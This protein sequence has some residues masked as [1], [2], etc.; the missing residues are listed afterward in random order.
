MKTV[1]TFAVALCAILPT[2][3]LAADVTPT[4]A[5]GGLRLPAIFSDNMVLQAGVPVPVWGW[6]APG[7]SVTISVAGQSVTAKADAQGK[8]KAM[9]APLQVADNLT[10]TAKGA[11]ATWTAAN[12]LVGEVWLAS[13]QSNMAMPKSHDDRLAGVTT[14][15]PENRQLRLFMIRQ[16][17]ESDV[18]LEDLFISDKERR[19]RWMIADAKTVP[20]FSAAGYY[21]GRDLQAALNRPVGV[22]QTAIGGVPAQ[23]YVNRAVLSADPELKVFVERS[24]KQWQETQ[25]R[26][27]DFVKNEPALLKHY[28]A[29]AAKAVA[30]GKKPPT[31]PMRPKVE[32]NPAW[33]GLAYNSRIAPIIPYAIKGVVWYQGESNSAG[34][35]RPLFPALIQSWRK[36]WGQRDFPFLFVQITYQD[37][38]FR[39]VQ[40]QITKTVP[41]TGM[42]V[43]SDMGMRG[44]PAH[45][46]D[47]APVGA[48]LALAARALAY[49]EKTEGSGPVYES[50]KF[51][52]PKAIVS[53][54]HVGGG[55]VARHGTLK[56]FQLAG[57]DKKFA[58][59][60]AEIVGDTVEVTSDQVPAPVA[61]RY[62]FLDRPTNEEV[63]ANGCRKLAR[64]HLQALPGTRH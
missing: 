22:I 28:E 2:F 37:G 4:P 59:A 23:T 9:L 18:P 51:A 60:K 46:H 48:R 1:R 6:A 45:P 56:G 15:A 29:D 24:E 21:F 34:E 7:E 55:L 62:G 5:A 44:D 54:S 35:Y 26:A 43:I 16:L 40:Q 41:N 38:K 19:G 42:A 17:K 57:A 27:A 30:E 52:G 49:G 53:F 14:P 20:D 50:V 61:V 33:A 11:S 39:E 12:V 47:K 63:I 8:W 32:M 36:E 13:G 25:Q 10:F 58:V 64:D 3:V 31:K